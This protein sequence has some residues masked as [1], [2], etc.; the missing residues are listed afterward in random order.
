MSL[1]QFPFA[2]TSILSRG[3]SSRDYNNNDNIPFCRVCSNKFDCISIHITNKHPGVSRAIA[4][5]SWTSSH[6]VVHPMSLLLLQYHVML[7]RDSFCLKI[8]VTYITNFNV[9][10]VSMTLTGRGD[11]IRMLQTTQPSTYSHNL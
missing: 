10:I 1:C 5:F 2:R 9:N 11:T 8:D 6:T 3:S 7:N 4:L